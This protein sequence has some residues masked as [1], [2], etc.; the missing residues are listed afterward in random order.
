MLV[1]ELISCQLV[2]ILTSEFGA[3]GYYQLFE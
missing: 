1:K 3:E 2:L